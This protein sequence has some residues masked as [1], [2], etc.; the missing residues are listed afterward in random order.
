M[1][2][3]ERACARP[4]SL[5]SNLCSSRPPDKWIVLEER[6]NRVLAQVD[7]DKTPRRFAM[8]LVRGVSYKNLRL[9]V[10]AKPVEGKEEMVAGLVWRYKDADTAR[11]TAVVD[12]D[13]HLQTLGK[14]RPDDARDDI[15][16]AAGRGGNDEP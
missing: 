12:D 13:L 2:S 4:A 14:L 11:T 15:G 1:S 10:K 6:G 3:G 7:R 16:T 8:A 5:F 9:S